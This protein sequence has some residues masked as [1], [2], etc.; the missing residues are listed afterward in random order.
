MSTKHENKNLG[1]VPRALALALSLVITSI[2]AI[3]FASAT[4]YVP[5]RHGTVTVEA[6]AD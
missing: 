5:T 6:V 4:D 1:L 2:V 3:G